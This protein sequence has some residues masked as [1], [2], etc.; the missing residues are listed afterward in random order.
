MESG[1]SGR[2]NKDRNFT[3]A[4][5][6][7]FINLADAKLDDYLQRLDQS[8]VT[9]NGTIGS[10]V[11]NLAEKIAAIGERRTPCKAM[12]A[13]SDRTGA[14]QISLTGPDRQAMAA[15]TRVGV[16]DHVQSECAVA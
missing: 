4:S 5:L 11:K 2:V 15:H 3:R 6:T 10:R 8:D 12:V 9:E 7:Q 1:D 16:A 13:Q 14:D